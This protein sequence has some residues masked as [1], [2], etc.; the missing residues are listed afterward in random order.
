MSVITFNQD[1]Y[2]NL[3]E[4]Y[5]NHVEP[6]QQ[7]RTF[8]EKLWTSAIR[9][10]KGKLNFFPQIV[11]STSQYLSEILNVWDRNNYYRRWFSQLS[12]DS[13][14]KT[15]SSWTSFLKPWNKYLREKHKTVPINYNQEMSLD[16]PSLI[17]RTWRT[18]WRTLALP[19]NLVIDTM[20][21]LALSADDMIAQDVQSPHYKWRKIRLQEMVDKRRYRF[22]S[23]FSI[24]LNQKIAQNLDKQGKLVKIS[25][26]RSQP[27]LSESQ[28]SQ[29]TQSQSSQSVSN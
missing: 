22:D 21:W 14:N 18:L 13:W 7:E 15:A 11:A 25:K 24:D 16:K 2:K 6:V 3:S 26:Q 28:S 23:L 4:S 27:Q 10:I 5:L 29:S 9:V 1:R 17:R 12:K 20:E 19:F 8:A